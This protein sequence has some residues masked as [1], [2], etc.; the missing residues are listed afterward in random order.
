[1]EKFLSKLRNAGE[2]V[3]T[4]VAEKDFLSLLLLLGKVL[5][6]SIFSI[7]AL[8]V[9]RALASL[10]IPVSRPVQGLVCRV[11]SQNEVIPLSSLPEALGI[12]RESLQTTFH[13]YLAE[14][15]DGFV[16][17]VD[18]KIVAYAWVAYG[19]FRFPA[20]N[21]KGELG[22]DE[23]HTFDSYVDLPYRYRGVYAELANFLSLYV[24]RRGIRWVMGQGDPTNRHSIKTHVKLGYRIVGHVILMNFPFGSLQVRKLERE[25]NRWQWAYT[26]RKGIGAPA[27][28]RL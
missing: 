10:K 27:E 2:Q 21:F 20:V 22:G 19:H 18:G 17:E 28:G 12:H 13:G 6:P 1:M 3:G 25:S 16:A 11:L 26:S 7:R 23:A 4:A 8:V 14:G 5:P 9:T 24:S 15:C